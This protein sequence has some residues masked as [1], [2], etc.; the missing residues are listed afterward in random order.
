MNYHQD[1]DS[2]DCGN[3]PE[4]K[5]KALLTNAL[6]TRGLPGDFYQA[7]KKLQQERFDITS[8]ACFNAFMDKLLSKDEKQ[9]LLR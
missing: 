9:R 7:V 8:M 6:K 3:T 4:Q 2:N 5:F 1:L